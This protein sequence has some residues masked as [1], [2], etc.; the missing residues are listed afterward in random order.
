[1]SSGSTERLAP[2]HRV[3]LSR[4]A[5]METAAA[6]SVLAM[7]AGCATNPVTGKSQLMFMSE[8]RELDID[9][10]YA[11]Q[12]FSAD[13][14]AVQDDDLN[15]YIAEVGDAIVPVTPRKDNPFSFRVLN[16][17]VVNGYTFPAGSIGLTRGLMVT[18]DNEAEMAGVLGHEIAHV[19]WRHAGER[20]S[21]NIMVMIALAGMVAYVQEEEEKYADL[22]AGLGMVGANLL[23]CRYSRSDEREA[24]EYGMKF[25][26]LSD[27]NPAGMKG[28]MEKFMALHKSEP[29]S[30]DLLFSTHPMS[31][32]RY[33]MAQTRMENEYAAVASR[34]MHRERYMDHTSRLR[35]MK[36]AIEDMQKGQQA[37]IMQK[38][39]EADSHFRSALKKKPADYAGLLMMS[40][41]LLAQGKN[42][43]AS[44]YANQ[45]KK[46]YPE[47]AQ[48][49]HVSAMV[50]MK[51]RQYDSALSQFSSYEELLP[52]NANTVFFKGQCFEKMGRKKEAAKEY[53]R[54]RVNAPSG[55]FSGQ[56]EQSLIN[57]GYIQPPQQGGK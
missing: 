54:Y 44:S 27:N 43:A 30:V 36:P 33:D 46:V 40:K 34:P 28:V 19:N 48:A 23:L 52:G 37:M 26:A 11:P 57:W 18:M 32:D 22:A 56:A 45:A 38:L 12:Q 47:E 14:G 41:C 7:L 49:L 13:Y 25:A 5:F 20:W 15:A 3:D 55:E 29:S 24:D 39:T 8:G 35:A 9:R 1:M 50:D 10:Q 17:V 31:K 2:C 51:M 4:R 16:A 53:K 6:S 21:K 42:K